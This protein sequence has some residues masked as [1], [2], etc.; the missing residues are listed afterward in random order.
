MLTP[1]TAINVNV[2]TNDTNKN[3]NW[4]AFSLIGIAVVLVVVVLFKFV[5]TCL[6]RRDITGKSSGQPAQ[7]PTTSSNILVNNNT[8]EL[9]TPSVRRPPVVP[10]QIHTEDPGVVNSPNTGNRSIGYEY[11]LNVARG[12]YAYIPQAHNSDVSSLVNTNE[13]YEVAIE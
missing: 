8:T 12:T 11:P 4:I 7:I 5:H 6:K 1:S 10:P 9:S 13:G 2:Y 3:M